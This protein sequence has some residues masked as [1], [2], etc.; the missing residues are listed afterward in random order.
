MIKKKDKEEIKGMI[1]E[2]DEIKKRG[3]KNKDKKIGK[4][5]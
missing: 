2:G 4:D 5:G 3:E 1:S